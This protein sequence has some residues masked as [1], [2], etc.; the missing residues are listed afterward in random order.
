MPE[1]DE[2]L[3]LRF[4][5]SLD[6]RA[7]DVLIGRHA[8]RAFSFAYTILG[9]APDAEDAV[10]D[11]LVRAIR[12]RYLFRADMSFDRW[13]YGILRNRC[14]DE[15]RRRGREH[16]DA[17]DGSLISDRPPADEELERREETDSLANA[18]RTLPVCDQELL[19]LRFGR[20]LRLSD[21]AAICGLTLESAK[22]RCQRVLDALR[23]RLARGGRP[24][25][26]VRK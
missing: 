16:P 8:S 13:F 18:L 6:E 3:F 17:S 2:R 5:D 26:F 23:R 4:R 25:V 11:T 20:G 19:A 15:L 14:R 22:K 24:S 1:A 9:D 10:Q 12:G 7:L 21:V